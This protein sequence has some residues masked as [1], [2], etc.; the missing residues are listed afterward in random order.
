M[1]GHLEVSNLSISFFQLPPQ[2]GNKVYVGT[3]ALGL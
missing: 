1:R 3:D 2:L